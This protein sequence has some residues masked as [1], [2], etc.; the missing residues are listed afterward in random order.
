VAPGRLHVCLF[1]SRP[2]WTQIISV[3]LV[4]NNNWIFFD[5][6]CVCASQLD[7]LRQRVRR[8]FWASASCFNAPV[9][10]GLQRSQTPHLES[11]VSFRR[12]SSAGRPATPTEREHSQEERSLSPEQSALRTE[13][14]SASLGR[15]WGG[16]VSRV[17]GDLNPNPSDR[18]LI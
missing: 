6:L 11:T 17:R 12:L 9:T 18:Y 16:E 1:V 5:L 15:K 14:G 3:I 4:D 2:A 10:S 13:R 8:H 7:K